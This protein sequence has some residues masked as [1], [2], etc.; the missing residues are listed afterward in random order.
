MIMEQSWI[1]HV[2]GHL[3]VK[4][5]IVLFKSLKKNKKID[6]SKEILSWSLIQT[7]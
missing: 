3:C 2:Q 4:K 6:K 1:T 5:S 7:R